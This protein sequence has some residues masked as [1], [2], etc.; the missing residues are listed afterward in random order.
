MDFSDFSVGFLGLGFT[1]ASD[2]LSFTDKV[3]RCA[4]LLPIMCCYH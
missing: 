3:A 2:A 4:G 1:G